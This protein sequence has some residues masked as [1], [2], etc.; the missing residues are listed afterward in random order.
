MSFVNKKRYL[1]HTIKIIIIILRWG[2]SDGPDSVNY[3]TIYTGVSTN[4]NNFPTG[5]LNLPTNDGGTADV[6]LQKNDVV[7]PIPR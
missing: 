3:V 5:M 6:V 2:A 7:I 4:T 1:I